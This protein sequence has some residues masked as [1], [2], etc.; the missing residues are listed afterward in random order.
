MQMNLASRCREAISH[1]AM[2]KKELAHHQKRAQEALKF[3]REQTQRMASNLSAEVSKLSFSQSSGD[4]QSANSNNNSPERNNNHNT[5]KSE[6]ERV[7][8]NM[9]PPPPPPPPRGSTTPPRPQTVVVGDPPA[10]HHDDDDE[11]S[12]PIIRTVSPRDEFNSDVGS[13]DE[14]ETVDESRRQGRSVLDVVESLSDLS[15]PMHSLSSPDS[16]SEHPPRV[17]STPDSKSELPPRVY[18]TPNRNRKEDR[19]TPQIDE[20]PGNVGKDSEGLTLFPHS[21]SPT[22]VGHGKHRNYNEDFPSDIVPHPSSSH[23]TRANAADL[24]SAYVEDDDDDEDAEGSFYHAT[25]PPPTR[26]QKYNGMITMNSIDA[27]EASFDTTF[28]S[29]FARKDSGSSSKSSRESP[30]SSSTEIYNPFAP[31]PA[32][33]TERAIPATP[34]SHHYNDNEG[35]PN[36]EILRTSNLSGGSQ[37]W[38]NENN[39]QYSTPPKDG[40]RPETNAYGEPIRPHKTPSEEA[41]ARYEKALQPRNAAGSNSS[42]ASATTTDAVVPLQIDAPEQKPGGFL[43]SATSPSR[44]LSRIHQRRKHNKDHGKDAP[45]DPEDQEYSQ[46]YSPTEALLSQENVAPSHRHSADQTSWRQLPSRS[47]SNGNSSRSTTPHR[48]DHEV[49]EKCFEGQEPPPEINGRPGGMVA[50]LSALKK[51]RSVKQPV[52][53]AEPALNTKIRQGHSYF[54]KSSTSADAADSPQPRIVTPEQMTNPV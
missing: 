22:V 40:R 34:P 3:Q 25:S 16:K 18:S 41:R 11:K 10:T 4:S 15:S 36:P 38:I 21:A 30:Q 2:L 52:S 44:F 46:Q 23:S 6:M 12:S 20:A 9:D 1:V 31:S 17:Y 28:P 54:P 8:A 53:Y 33:S 39:T 29:T 49:E 14:D 35:S 27:F 51:R 50:R 48:R 7:L 5:S 45:P 13:S 32:R 42:Q 19:W 47:K 37:P 26:L 43:Q 24:D